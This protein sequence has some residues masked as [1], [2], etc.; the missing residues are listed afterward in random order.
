MKHFYMKHF[1]FSLF[2]IIAIPG[3]ADLLSPSVLSLDKGAAIDTAMYKL[4]YRLKY[5]NHP[6]NKDYYEDIRNILIGTRYVK[7]FSDI[8]FHFDSL[9][10]AGEQKGLDT[11]SG[12]QGNPL[13]LETLVN[14]REHNAWIKYR[15]PLLGVTNLCYE[16]SIPIF[17]WRFMEGNDTIIGYECSKATTSF[18]GRDYTAWFTNELPLPYGPYKFGCLP[19]M[20]LRIQDNQKQFIWE[21]IGIE[22]NSSPIMVYNYEGEKHCSPGEAEKTIA[23]MFKSPIGFT[24]SDAIPMIIVGPDGKEYLSTQIK[25]EPIPYLPLEIK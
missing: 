24:S 23:R 9:R 16:Q 1:I 25:D 22:N 8:I 21:A 15:L 12:I 3:K 14:T 18:A 5:K 10:T 6:D 13:P 2:L 19:G 4:T 11:Y 7:D 17:D 20:I